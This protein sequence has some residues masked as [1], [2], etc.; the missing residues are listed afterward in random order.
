MEVTR[1]L[2]SQIHFDPNTM[3]PGAQHP[4]L[5]YNATEASKRATEW[6]QFAQQV[7]TGQ[8][9]GFV[10]FGRWGAEEVW[11]EK[12]GE[13]LHGVAS[14]C[15][16]VRMRRFLIVVCRSKPLSLLHKP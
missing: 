10:R 14:L 7:I 13:Y 3:L 9:S 15:G 1:F 2:A 6:R 4:N 5:N 11:R 12:C 8:G 16:L